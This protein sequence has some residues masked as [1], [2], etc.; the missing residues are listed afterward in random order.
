[1]INTKQADVRRFSSTSAFFVALSS[2]TLSPQNVLSLK[3]RNFKGFFC[4]VQD[5]Y[6]MGTGLVLDGHRMGT[7]QFKVRSKIIKI[8]FTDQK[9]VFLK[10]Q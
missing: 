9:T 2:L 3:N 7:G 10:S 8:T 1:M 5:G 6:R 4:W